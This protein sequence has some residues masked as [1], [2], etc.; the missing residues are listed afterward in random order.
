MSLIVVPVQI[1]KKPSAEKSETG[2]RYPSLRLFLRNA[3]VFCKTCVIRHKNPPTD[4][5]AGGFGGAVAPVFTERFGF[6]QD[7]CDTTQ[8]SAH[9]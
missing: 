3:L 4:E 8:K 6:L 1:M 9:R 5:T 2:F 7:L